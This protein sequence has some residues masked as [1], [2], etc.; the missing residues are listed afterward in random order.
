M[1][2]KRPSAWQLLMHSS[3]SVLDA[4]EGRRGGGGGGGRGGK[5]KEEC[6]QEVVYATPLLTL[7]CT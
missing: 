6:F 3:V 5:W 1:I 2:P 7:L 4:K